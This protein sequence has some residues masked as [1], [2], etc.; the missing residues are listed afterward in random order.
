[1]VAESG[2][3]LPRR[4]VTSSRVPAEVTTASSATQ[5]PPAPLMLL[6]LPLPGTL[7]TPTGTGHAAKVVTL[8]GSVCISP[9]AP[10]SPA[11]S[12]APVCMQRKCNSGALS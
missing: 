5:S 11:V 12:Q 6:G 3:T 10:A 7:P 1:M 2:V 9:A 8:C 4:T